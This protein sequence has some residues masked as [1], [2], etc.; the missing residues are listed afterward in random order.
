MQTHPVLEDYQYN[1]NHTGHGGIYAKPVYNLSRLCSQGQISPPEKMSPQDGMMS[2]PSSGLHA[3]AMYSNHCHNSSSYRYTSLTIPVMPPKKFRTEQAEILRCKRRVDLSH[4]LGYKTHPTAVA[5][6]NERERNRVKHI[7]S[8][9]ATLRQH[10]PCAAK[11]KKMSKV[12]TLRSAIKYINH[13]Q[14]ILDSQTSQTKTDVDD[15][16]ESSMLGHLHHREDILPSTT[17]INSPGKTTSY[18]QGV[19]FIDWPSPDFFN[20]PKISAGCLSKYTHI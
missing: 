2:H 4:K 13:L 5:R 15:E 17:S 20:F 18:F 8:T 14:H 1:P 11:N 16:E 3:Q 7:N 10:I 12:E 6:R 19:I 9:F